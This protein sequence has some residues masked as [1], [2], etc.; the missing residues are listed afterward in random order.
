MLKIKQYRDEAKGLADLLNYACIPSDGVALGKDG[1]FT[2]GL[3]Y[4][5]DDVDSSTPE[6]L[7]AMSAR[8]NAALAKLGNGWMVKTDSIRQSVDTYPMPENAFPDP[9]TQAIDDERRRHFRAAGTQFET[10]HVLM[11]TYLPPLAIESK[12]YTFLID[13]PN[14]APSNNFASKHL[15]YF[16]QSLENIQMDLSSVV[17]MQRLRSETVVDKNGKTIVYDQ[18]LQYIKY[19]V[20]GDNHPLR[21]PA[22]PMY[23]DAILGWQDFVGGLKPQIGKKRISVLS[24]DGFPQEGE[25]AILRQLSNLGCEYRWNTRFIFMDRQ[26]ARAELESY[27]KKWKQKVRGFRDQIFQTSNGRVDDHA[28]MNVR[29]V[30]EALALIESGVVAFGYYTSVVVLMNEDQAKLQED[31]KDVVRTISDIGFSCREESI[32]A[33]E[34]WLG[35]LPSHSL[36]N[37]RRP[38]MHTMN[39]SDLLP[40]TSVWPGETYNPSPLFP[41]KSP[42]IFQ[43]FTAGNTAFRGNLHVGDLGHFL[44]FGPPGSGKSLMIAFLNAQ[45]CRYLGARIFSFDNGYSQ[46]ALTMGVK[47][48]HYDIAGEGSTLK[49]CPLASIGESDEERAWAKEWIA[50]ACRYQ[51]FEIKSHHNTAIHDAIELLKN[52]H[53]KTMTDFNATLQDRE[54][55][56]VIKHFTLEGAMGHL[57]DGE[58]DG[59]RFGNFQ[60]IEIKHLMN[61]GDKNALPVLEYIFHR[62]ETT[63]VGTGLPAILPIDEAWLALQHPVFREKIRTWL[64]VMRR[65]N[66]CIGLA[67]QS[68]SDAANSGIL[69]VI[70]ETCQTKIFGANPSASDDS[71]KKFYVALGL[72]DKQIKIIASLTPKR[73]YYVVQPH[74]KRVIQLG[75]GP[76]AL[77]WLGVSARE[78]LNRLR[79]LIK[80]QPNDWRSIWEESV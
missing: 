26:E 75:I 20:T 19:T 67:T 44:V 43:A 60:T 58:D 4:I 39:L 24:I 21:L 59:L 22:N 6:E 50:E 14:K 41:K 71:S 11:F 54:L 48:L 79:Q 8:I 28:L 16:E 33:V 36:E 9:I 70:A 76:Y 10:V 49:F 13:D 62:I 72:N 30:D 31:T 61:L 66:V 64:K 18:L 51:G 53:S 3:Y 52:A 2:G 68:V 73:D 34:A 7:N 63:L 77:K 32:N 47:G 1:S 65:E 46:L 27:R 29:E 69:D 40:M 56:E 42:P 55:R 15:N 25:P 35:S 17:R 38:I 23:L 37:V 5:G 74:G 78:D 45:F 12:F 57:L 80:D